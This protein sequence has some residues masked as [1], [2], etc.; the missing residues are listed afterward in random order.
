[1]WGMCGDNVGHVLSLSGVCNRH[2]YGGVGFMWGLCG[3]CVGQCQCR[4][5][6]Q[7]V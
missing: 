7:S 3:A 6:V 2:V 4:V 1:M 5:S